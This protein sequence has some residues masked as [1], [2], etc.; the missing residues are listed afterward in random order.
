MPAT[1]AQKRASKKWIEKNKEQHNEL[2]MKWLNEN[3]EKHNELNKIRMKMNYDF[4]NDC[5]IS[6]ELKRFRRILLEL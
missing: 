2:K 3:R 4:K 5:D 6:I 1:E